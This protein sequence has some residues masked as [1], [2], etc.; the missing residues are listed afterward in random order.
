[1]FPLGVGAGGIREAAVMRRALDLGVNYFD[2]AEVYQEG[3]SEITLGKALAGRRDE[4]VVATKWG[5]WEKETADDYVAALDASLK[6]L[7]MDYVDIIQIHAAST[8][9]HVAIE[10]ARE[11]FE[12]AHKAGKVRF[13]GISTHE[14]QVEI[15]EAI[16]AQGWYDQI[17]LVYNAGNAQQMKPVIRKAREAGIGIVAMKGLAPVHWAMK[18]KGKYDPDEP[19][20]ALGLESGYTV[21]P[22]ELPD[23]PYRKA[24]QW[25]WKDENV[26]NLIVS[27]PT[28]DQVEAGVAAARGELTPAD[29]EKFEEA[30]IQASLGMCRMCGACT[31]QCAKAVQVA[32]IMRYRLYHDGYGDRSRAVALYRAL[33]PGASAAACGDCTNCPVVCPWGVPVQERMRDLHS[34]LA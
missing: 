18:A 26:A 19:E 3:N 6:R 30:I 8:R 4:A 31:G 15:V 16:I 12:R 23:E 9:E 13:N 34:R 25:V 2:T 22:H 10:A 24:M 17:L 33:R 29:Q 11:A 7:D 5:W 21:N 32:D 14:N 27:M 1:V 20:T 28:F